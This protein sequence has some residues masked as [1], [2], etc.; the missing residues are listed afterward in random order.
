M[1]DRP[2]APGARKLAALMPGGWLLGLPFQAP[3]QGAGSDAAVDAGSAP[4]SQHRTSRRRLA[5]RP[6]RPRWN[7]KLSGP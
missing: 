3:A 4:C 1:V 5:R 7:G 2:V 6:P